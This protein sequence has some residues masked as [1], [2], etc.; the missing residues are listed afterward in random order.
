M[1]MR[2][3]AVVLDFLQ[4]CCLILSPVITVR[5]H[6]GR[7][8]KAWIQQH[9]KWVR[10]GAFVPGWQGRGGDD[11]S[12]GDC[13]G[14]A[15]GLMSSISVGNA[16]VSK[17]KGCVLL[18]VAGTVL[19][20][21]RLCLPA[22]PWLPGSFKPN[23]GVHPCSSH[24][25]QALCCRMRCLHMDCHASTRVGLK[26]VAQ[27]SGRIVPPLHTPSCGAPSPGTGNI[28]VDGECRC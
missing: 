28:A 9:V 22:W 26:H 13:V 21:L 2:P 24:R 17:G 15:W 6:R 20:A 4:F 25:W 12:G 10:E 23:L 19:I 7:W 3:R 18:I 16:G 1:L 14:L 5:M 27:C 11:N 8:E